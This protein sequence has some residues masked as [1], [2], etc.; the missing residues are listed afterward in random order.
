[1]VKL[2]LYLLL[3]W[4]SHECFTEIFVHLSTPTFTTV[5]LQ[6][7]RS[8][9]CGRR[10]ISPKIKLWIVWKNLLSET[11]ENTQKSLHTLTVGESF[12]RM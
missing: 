8:V 9:C 12:N 5:I 4:F 1:M 3:A 11:N 6:F 7:N 10:K 2:V